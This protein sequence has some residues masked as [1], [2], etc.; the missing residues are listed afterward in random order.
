MKFSFWLLSVCAL[1][2]QPYTIATIAGGGPPPSSVPA[3][4]APVPISGGIAANNAG[5]V[6]FAGGNSVFKVDAKGIL[7]R[8][9]GAGRFGS[10]GDG[11]AASS[12]LLAWPAGL[13]TD[14][15]GNVYIAENAGHRIRKVSPDGIIATVAG[16]GAAGDSGDGGAAGNA[17]L[18]YPVGIAVDTSGN[19]YIAD[20]GN[21]RVRKVSS[22]GLITTV[23]AGLDHAEGVAVDASGNVFVTDYAFGEAACPYDCDPR[24]VGRILRVTP[25]G[26]VDKVAGGLNWVTNNN[27]G[28]Q[29]EN[30][31]ATSAILQTPRG[32]AVDAAGIV[33]ISDTENNRVRK[34]SPGGLITTAAGVN[35]F[36]YHGELACTYRSIIR[37]PPLSC[38]VGVA[39]DAE[40]NLYVADTGN[41]RIRKI[42]PLGVVS[43]IAG[44]GDPRSYW[45]DGGRAEDAALYYPSGV[46]VDA[47]A[48][49][50]IADT[51]NSRVRKVSPEGV[52]TTVAGN[53]T[54]GYS[55]DGGPAI[56]AQLRG[57]G[58]VAVDA[59][60][61]LYIADTADHRIRKVS[62]SGIITTIA[63]NGVTGHG[64]GP[65]SDG[66]PATSANLAGPR[67][68]AVDPNGNV[69]I[70]DTSHLSIRK[71]STSGIITTVAGAGLFAGC[72]SGGF[73]LPTAVAVDTSS[74][75]YI[76]DQC[77]I[78]KLSPDGVV[79]SVAPND[80]ENYNRSP[81]L[82]VD[83]EGNI[84]ILGVQIRRVARDGTISTVGGNGTPGYSGD[85]GPASAAS[86]NNPLG[87][88]VNAAGEIY[89]ADANNHVI[90][91][92][93]AVK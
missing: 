30:G 10:A 75:L 68:V 17:Q 32:I 67:G 76:A 48:N 41:S 8:F 16:T 25:T 91:M 1:S 62:P 55:G 53:G 60:G 39:L 19:L 11:G 79:V 82:A 63:G 37:D 92:L 80:N 59:F 29:D 4:G 21:R 78:R 71:V 70:A 72:Q 73:L 86:F 20:A 15:S 81:A 14:A 66:G 87:I 24:Y 65:W 13:A 89:V 93:R 45:G 50:Y 5:D 2:A 74:Q 36:L 42:S 90:R 40:G 6:Y 52:I 7:T 49:L 77:G 27:P 84:F 88:A 22:E 64:F 57:P 46:A 3:L 33:Y 23:V 54:S 26:A 83:T 9:A 35:A 18:H 61:N 31:P 51:G 85:G 28:D 43:N 12:A 34:F 58:G 56:D 69:Y 47:S 44:S 38:P